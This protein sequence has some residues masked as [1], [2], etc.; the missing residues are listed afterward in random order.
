MLDQKIYKVYRNN[1]EE[2]DASSGGGNRNKGTQNCSKSNLDVGKI[3]SM[4]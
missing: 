3:F 1:E 4:R 2:I